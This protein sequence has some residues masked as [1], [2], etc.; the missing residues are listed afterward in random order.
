M[1]WPN[2]STSSFCN[3]E[4]IT[5]MTRE[6]MTYRTDQSVCPECHIEAA[7]AGEQGR[8]FAVVADEVRKLAE[9]SSRAAGE[10]DAITATISAQSVA[11]RR[12]IGEGL[13]HL[14]SARPPSAPVAS[15]LEAT[16]GSGH[17]GRPRPRRH[18]QP[19]DHR[20]GR[21]ARWGGIESI[22][23]GQDTTGPS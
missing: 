17:R 21:Q 16:N 10:I 19:T 4:A 5:H 13:E 8:G 15:V 18:R 23:H 1:K 22:C 6:V 2:R 3:T 9:K 14:E 20:G 7:R 12:T 11:V